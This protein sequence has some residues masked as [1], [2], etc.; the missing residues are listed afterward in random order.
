MGALRQEDDLLLIPD[1]D[2]VYDPIVAIGDDDHV[3][4]I[5]RQLTSPLAIG[6]RVVRKEGPGRPSQPAFIAQGDA[7]AETVEPLLLDEGNQFAI[8][9][10][11]TRRIMTVV[12]ANDTHAVPLTNK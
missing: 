2:A 1:R 8:Y 7:M 12:H 4:I 9:D 3:Q 6:K 5:K 11:S 10:Q